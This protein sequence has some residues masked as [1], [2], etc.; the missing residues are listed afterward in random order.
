MDDIHEIRRRNL[1][2]LV[3]EHA[4]GNLTRFVEV[5]LGDRVAYKGLANVTR[6]RATRNLGSG[7]AR[8][9]EV[10]LRLPRGWMDHDHSGTVHTAGSVPGGRSERVMRLAR[11][12]EG[13]SRDQLAL[14]EQLVKTLE[15]QDRRRK[16]L[17]ITKSNR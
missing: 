8:L 17:P 1:R 14:I 7:M 16:H 2:S 15:E 11:L 4:G 13:L 5:N 12:L 10:M 6:A 3:K 9:I